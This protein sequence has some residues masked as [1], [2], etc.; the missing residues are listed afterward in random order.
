MEITEAIP[1]TSEGGPEGG[2]GSA[3]RFFVLAGISEGREPRS[4]LIFRLRLFRP[5]NT[6]SYS[7]R[8]IVYGFY[9]IFTLLIRSI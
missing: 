1:A 2:A 5:R 9:P 6:F 8:V 3:V 7:W 4:H